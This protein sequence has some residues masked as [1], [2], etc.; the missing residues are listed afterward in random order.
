MFIRTLDQ[1]LAT[2]EQSVSK[3]VQI[4]PQIA[5]GVPRVRKNYPL[6]FLA[7]VFAVV[8]MA[9]TVY[10]TALVALFFHSGIIAF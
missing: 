2:Q 9:T 5:H 7:R 6:R 8:G 10:A 1:R 4:A 3:S